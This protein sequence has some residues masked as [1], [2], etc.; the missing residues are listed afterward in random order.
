M[1]LLQLLKIPLYTLDLH[2]SYHT[3][4]FSFLKMGEVFTQNIYIE[5]IF[6]HIRDQFHNLC[7]NTDRRSLLRCQN[8]SEL[9]RLLSKLFEHR[10]K[11]LNEIKQLFSLG[12]S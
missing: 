2:S 1:D 4:S 11:I 7:C 5:G 10:N 8:C 6:N 9:G 12:P 3:D